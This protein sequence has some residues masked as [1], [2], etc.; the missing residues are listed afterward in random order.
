[1]QNGEVDWWEQP[2]SDLFALLRRNRNVVLE[3]YDPTGFMAVGRFN[4][5]HPPFDKAG[6]R[7]A[8]LGAVNQAD[9]MTAVT[10][11]DRSLWRENVGVFPPETPMAT[12]A[13]L[14]ALTA[15]RDMEKVKRELAAAGYNGEKVTLIAAADFPTLFALAQVG[16][17]MMK[18][19]GINVDLVASDWGTVVQRRARREAPDKGGWS[20]FFTFWSGLD[21]FNPG[22][23]QSLRGNGQA[24][25]FGWPT[26][27]K[28]E[29]LRDAWLDA[30]DL[31][32]QQRVAAEVQKQAMQDVPYLPLGQYFPAWAYRRNVTGVLKGLP[33]FWNVQRA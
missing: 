15:P 24:A 23:S 18:Q 4:Q 13:G 26:A 28:L 17:D 16:A 8:L 19:A 11:T 33:L 5:L 2:G 7:R 1:M 14:E 3:L 29:E 32:A 22:V 9:F 31:A 21:M 12:D 10:G 27:P 30:P 25:W 6:V 20:M